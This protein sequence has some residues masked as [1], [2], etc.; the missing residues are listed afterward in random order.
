MLSPYICHNLVGAPGDGPV[1]I[2]ALGNL[3]HFGGCS[4]NHLLNEP[5][6]GLVE[7][8]SA[9]GQVEP[10]LDLIIAI[11]V[12]REPVDIEEDPQGPLTL[13]KALL[14][15]TEELGQVPQ[16]MAKEVK[17]YSDLSRNNRT[18]L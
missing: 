14:L 10:N 11:M 18:T 16:Q 8:H 1:R 15:G 3:P 12:Q 7:D 5:P 2:I 6:V 17:R 4:Y 13:H 9:M